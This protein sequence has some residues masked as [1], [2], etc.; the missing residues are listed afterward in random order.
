MVLIRAAVVDNDESPRRN[1]TTEKNLHFL[2]LSNTP[3]PL[4]TLGEENYA[5]KI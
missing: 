2:P 1:V 3:P 5:D 4:L